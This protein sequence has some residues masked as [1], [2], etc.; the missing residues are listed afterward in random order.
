MKK[1]LKKAPTIKDRIVRVLRG[2]KR[3]LTPTELGLKLGFEK[4]QASALVGPAL[5]KLVAEGLVD[6]HKIGRRVE[7]AW[8]G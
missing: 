2:R 7:Y 6:R 1:E 3:G 5:K 4:K 8:V